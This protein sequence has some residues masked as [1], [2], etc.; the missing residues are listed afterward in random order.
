MPLCDLSGESSDTGQDVQPL[1]RRGEADLQK[2]EGS[3]P[4]AGQ[5]GV[6]APLPVHLHCPLCLRDPRHQLW[7]H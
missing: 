5:R 2:A 1:Q 7:L 4:E 6:P 3:G